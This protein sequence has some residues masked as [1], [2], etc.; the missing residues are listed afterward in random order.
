MADY[1]E[2]VD[3]LMQYYPIVKKAIPAYI[4][5]ETLGSA[6]PVYK[7]LTLRQK[8]MKREN[9]I[10]NDNYYHRLGMH[11]AGSLG[12]G[13][14][15]A[16]LGGGLIKE[17]VDLYDKSVKGDM[18]WRESLSDS[19]K[20]MQNNVEAVFRGLTHPNEDARIWLKDLNINTNTWKK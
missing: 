15:I 7:N 11:E 12:L 14:A 3:N 20:D 5:G 16:G 9:I 2:I 4:V 8:Q 13:G 1:K 18:P 10:N 6:Y 19:Y 17:G